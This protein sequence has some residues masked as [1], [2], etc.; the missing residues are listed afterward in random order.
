VL[1]SSQFSDTAIDAL[2]SIEADATL[3]ENV[4]TGDAVVNAS[5]YEIRNLELEYTFTNTRLNFMVAPYVQKRNYVDSDEFDQKNHG[6]RSD[7]HWLLRRSLTLGIYG[8]YENLEYTQLNREDETTRVGATLR[9]QWTRHWSAGLEWE[10]YKRDSNA[11]GQS[12]SQ[13][14]VYLSIS[15]SNR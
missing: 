12:V 4:L 2:S 10:R 6:L 14:L 1:A 5:P 11:A 9:Y 15:Y 7:L 13:N 8:T 3:P